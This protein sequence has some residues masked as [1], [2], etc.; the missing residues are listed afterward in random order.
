MAE[1]PIDNEGEPRPREDRTMLVDVPKEL[2]SYQLSRLLGRG[3]MGEVWLGFDTKLEREVAVKLMR[4]E[5]LANDEAVKRFYREARSVA[6]LN[7]PNIVQVYYIGEERGVIYFVMEYVEGETVTEKLKR[8]GPLALDD[9]VNILLQTV[10]GLSYANARGI[11]HRDIKPSNLMLTRDFRVK[12][13]DFGLAKMIEHDTQVT[14]SGTAMG[15]P[16]YMSPEQSRGEEADHRSDIYALGISLYQVL[17]GTLP[18]SAPTPLTVLLKQ[19]QEPLPE[20]E[21]LKGL[22]GGR[23]LETIKKMA[24]KDPEERYQTYGGLAAAVSELAP[25]VAVR[26]ST[27][28][29]TAT[30]EPA[31]PVPAGA[32]ADTA[33]SGAVPD[34]AEGTSRAPGPPRRGTLFALA[35]GAVVIAALSVIAFVLLRG[36]DSAEGT[37]AAT[38]VPSAPAT[39]ASSPPTAATPAPSPSPAPA[40]TAAATPQVTPSQNTAPTPNTLPTLQ[41]TPM[42]VATPTPLQN[43]GLTGFPP[44]PGHGRAPNLS[45]SLQWRPTRPKTWCLVASAQPL[46]HRCLCSTVQAGKSP[47]FPQERTHDFCASTRAPTVLPAM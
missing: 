28:T 45:R 42:P 6:R 32:A 30:M 3:G 27:H 29:A 13:A 19:I 24:A 43:R 38:A 18:F 22:A 47:R 4:R 11:I 16:N 31:P 34:A 20:P 44:A 37:A 39:Q 12:I 14:A 46:V 41:P 26:P 7:H 9:A 10:E 40:E 15:S 23:V 33:L 36:S 1:D 25:A 35:A 21:Q 5:L 17:T 8:E 2:G